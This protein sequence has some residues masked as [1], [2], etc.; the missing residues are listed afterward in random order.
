[1]KAIVYDKYGAPD[2]VL[3]LREI[4]KPAVSD[5]EVLVRVRAAS[6]N[7][8]DW[9]MFRGLPYPM[10]MMTGLSKPKSRTVL[11]SD[12]AGQV[13]AVGKNVS[14]FRPGDEVYA[15]VGSGGFAEYVSVS[16]D[17]LAL[18]PANL[19]FE[20]S[21]AV[22]MAAETALQ[23][24]RDKG[25]AQSGQ[26]VLV[27]GASGGVGTFAVQIAKHFGAEVTGVCST[28]NVDLVRSIGADHVVDYTQE[29]FMQGDQ[30]F[31]LILD[32]VGNHSI[33]EYRRVMT[34][35]GT[36]GAFG[37]GGGRWLGPA[38]QQLKAVATSP[39]V[40]QNLV[41]VNDK[42]NQSLG[43]LSELL[44]A[45]EVTPVIDRTYP[46]SEAP[47]AMCYLEEGHA[48]GK[49]VITVAEDDE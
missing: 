13:E 49:I 47:D 48:R 1:M 8:Y 17:S 16:E 41:P 40:S 14:Q 25:N 32:A 22:P 42:P 43:F 27:N 5:D 15:E 44:E 37:G 28:R 3:E 6:A 20:Q 9:H 19:S 29:D 39:F 45:G 21:A 35:K 38:S 7:P 26:K 34:P 31:D 33:S 4:D 11:G 12:M 30:R 18:K 23:G 24:V 46:L 2:E 36:Y 10:R